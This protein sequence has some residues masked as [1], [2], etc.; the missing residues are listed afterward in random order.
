MVNP[1]RQHIAGLDGIRFVCAAIVAL[2]HYY[3]NWTAAL[4]PYIGAGIAKLIGSGLGVLF[5]GPAAVI[6]FFVLSGF[7]I[8]RGSRERT[9][10]A[11]FYAKRFIRIVPPAL[12]FMVVYTVTKGAPSSWNNTVLWSLFCEGIYYAIYPALRS[13]G[14]LRAFIGS[15]VLMIAVVTVNFP[16][17]RH[18][19]YVVL[20]WM[21]WAVGLPVWLG[22]CLVAEHLERFPVAARSLWVW[23][24][25]LFA[26]AIVFRI[27]KFHAGPFI[28]SNVIWLTLFA[29]P[30][31]WWIG[32][33]A[34]AAM[35]KDRMPL[36]R[37]GAASYTLYLVHPLVAFAPNP[38][39]YVLA[40]AAATLVFY[41]LIELPSHVAARAIG[42]RLDARRIRADGGS[43]VSI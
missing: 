31:A 7:V 11:P 6:V 19:D 40:V 18:T 17:L 28:G 21:T 14:I 25:G 4:E 3:Y 10:I 33:E 8:H 27:A 9:D 13:I 41:R 32:L 22:G 26:A 15:L 23:R 35:G 24:L 43:T 16:A 20:G 36:D 2:G 38:L 5:N 39:L 1:A 42:R 37:L 12:A 29:L 34:R 30:V